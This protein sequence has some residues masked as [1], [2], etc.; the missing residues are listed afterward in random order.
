[1]D[2]G[3]RD[4]PEDAVAEIRQHYLGH[5]LGDVA[6]DSPEM[7]RSFGGGK[8]GK[9]VGQGSAED[10]VD[11]VGLVVQAFLRSPPRRE[12]TVSPLVAPCGE[13]TASPL[14]APCGGAAARAR[15]RSSHEAG[16][17]VCARFG[18]QL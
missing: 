14:V 17:G 11:W 7:P 5:G 18:D 8:L 12:A 6:H 13:A 3:Y 2:A 9:A 16:A 15:A 10:G 1:M 4:V